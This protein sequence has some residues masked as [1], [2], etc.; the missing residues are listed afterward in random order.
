MELEVAMSFFNYPEA[1]TIILAIFVL[2]LA[3]EH[4]S[5]A[6]RRHIIA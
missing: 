3:V 1:A 5:Q 4:A 2:V 6:L